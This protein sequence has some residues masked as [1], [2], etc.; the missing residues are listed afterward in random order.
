MLCDFT[1]TSRRRSAIASH[2]SPGLLAYLSKVQDV[3][4]VEKNYV[5]A[6]FESSGVL[7]FPMYVISPN[8]VALFENGPQ[9]N[10]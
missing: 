4:D 3:L 8:R 1:R 9:L 6:T 10:L 7:G 2:L 5:I